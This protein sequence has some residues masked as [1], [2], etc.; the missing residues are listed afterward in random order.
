M[1]H[2]NESIGF[3]PE[4]IK[5]LSKGIVILKAIEAM[6]KSKMEAF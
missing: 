5:H 6:Y 2:I 4:L 1:L 3:S